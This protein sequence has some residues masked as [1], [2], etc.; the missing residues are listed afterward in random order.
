[1]D[2]LFEMLKNLGGDRGDIHMDNVHS[3]SF[4]IFYIYIVYFILTYKYVIPKSFIYL[5]YLS[6]SPLTLGVH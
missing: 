4:V 2:M 1:M 3:M 5:I 6:F